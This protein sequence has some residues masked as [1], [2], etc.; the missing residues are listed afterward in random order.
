G[1]VSGLQSSMTENAGRLPNILGLMDGKGSRRAIP[2]QMR[3]EGVWKGC[4]G[5]SDDG[6]PEPFCGLRPKL[7]VKPQRVAEISA[8]CQNGAPVVKIALEIRQE[9]LG[10]CRRDADR[11]FDLGGFEV[12]RPSTVTQL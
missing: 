5:S 8:R 10:K 12:Q 3:C 9:I 4:P 1:F 6:L 11:I 2:E 7:I